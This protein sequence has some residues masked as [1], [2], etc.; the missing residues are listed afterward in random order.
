MKSAEQWVEEM[1]LF[2]TFSG[3]V[4]KEKWVKLVKKIQEDAM[5]SMLMP[6]KI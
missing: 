3:E 5:D 4:P 6:Y 2:I 1:V